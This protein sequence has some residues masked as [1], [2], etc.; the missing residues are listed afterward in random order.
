MNSSRTVARS[1]AALVVL[2]I[3]ATAV[4]WLVLDDGVDRWMNEGPGNRAPEVTDDL[5]G[6]RNALAADALER[7]GGAISQS[8]RANYLA[9]WDSSTA[10]S[11]Q[12]A[13]TTY[14]NLRALGVDRL[15]TRYVA[16]EVGLGLPRQRRLGGDAWKAAVEVSY[17]L[18]GYGPSPARTTVSYTFVERGDEVL[19]IDMQ[20]AK[21]ERAPIWLFDRLAVRRSERTL[22]A[23]SS[24][25]DAQHISHRLQQAVRDVESVLPAWEG[26]LLA[27]SPG[28]TEQ[29]EEVL[30]AAPGSY[31]NIAAV[32]TTMDGSA[33]PTSQV[34]IVIHDKV[35]NRLGPIGSRVVI[36]HEST[37]AATDAAVVKMPL[38]V[39][40]GFADYVG[41]GAVE[42]PIAVSA[43][44]VT[45]DVRRNGVPAHL[46]ANED[47][48]A[49]SVDLELA[50]EQAWL[51]NR[52]IARRYGERSLVRFYRLVVEQPD[53][54]AR[55]FRELGTTQEAFTKR[56]RQSL[57][58]M[59]SQ[60]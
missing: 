60:G 24:T 54:L 6:R 5:A 19:I 31:D 9:A 11:Q 21:G 39:A 57:R 45:R 2:V 1:L 17:R 4:V 49:A 20:A 18:N 40:E 32:T 55:A 37:H 34:M 29:L 35:F 50:Y 58:A 33:R 56:W 30:A 52:L 41:V 28:S 44:A 26:S 14:R 51:A 15:A 59:A 53:D 22:A 43:R 47:F 12:R 36:T 8:S 13:H 46:P 25:A 42:V 3:A 48:S 7:Q 16:T 38:W 10:M 23:A 27:Y